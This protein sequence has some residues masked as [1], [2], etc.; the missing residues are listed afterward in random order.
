MGNRG[1]VNF[2]QSRHGLVLHY[3]NGSLDLLLLDTR[4]LIHNFSG[5]NVRD[6]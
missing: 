4:F 2:C 5:L 1:T 6:F 3:F